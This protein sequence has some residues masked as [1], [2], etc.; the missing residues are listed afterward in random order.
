MSPQDALR[1][2]N[3][4]SRIGGVQ[5]TQQAL[6]QNRDSAGMAGTNQPAQ[7]YNTPTW[8][9]TGNRIPQPKT[10][11]HPKAWGGT[12]S[13]RIETPQKMD[14]SP[15]VMGPSKPAIAPQ[16]S[17]APQPGGL[18]KA[19]AFSQGAST[20]HSDLLPFGGSY[21]QDGFASPMLAAAILANQ[22]R[23]T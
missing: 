10:P 5:Q 18:A 3:A 11:F 15:L 6:T 4:I 16:P 9:T 2:D 1:L 22:R 23:G 17:P 13:Q 8:G 19:G 21:S 14:D 7:T 20:R 12:M